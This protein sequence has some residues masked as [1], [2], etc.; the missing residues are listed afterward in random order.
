MF[1]PATIQQKFEQNLGKIKRI[2]VRH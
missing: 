1:F 2:R